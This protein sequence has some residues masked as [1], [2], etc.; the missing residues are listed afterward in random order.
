MITIR[1]SILECIKI[2]TAYEEI[3]YTTMLKNN[4]KKS[5]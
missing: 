4:E 3:K 1:T 5:I 2:D